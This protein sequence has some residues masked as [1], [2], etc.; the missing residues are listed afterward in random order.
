MSGR[1]Q[2][3]DDRLKPVAGQRLRNPDDRLKPVAA[4]GEKP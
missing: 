2:G 4:G 3:P 1:M